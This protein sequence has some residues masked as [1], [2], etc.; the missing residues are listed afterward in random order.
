MNM[1][2]LGRGE[3]NVP[4]PIKGLMIMA[5]RAT[6]AEALMTV[7]VLGRKRYSFE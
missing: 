2:R 5:L 7:L 1:S 6:L 4:D 3:L